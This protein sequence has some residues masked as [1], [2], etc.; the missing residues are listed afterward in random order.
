MIILFCPNC[1]YK[2]DNPGK[3]CSGCG[4]PLDQLTQT[5]ALASSSA[6]DTSVLFSP[7]APAAEHPENVPPAPQPSAPQQ[8]V[9]GNAVPII[10][11][12]S[13]S[14]GQFPPNNAA[15]FIPGN[16]PVNNAHDVPQPPPASAEKKKLKTSDII[17]ISAAALV[18]VAAVI[19]VVVLLLGKASNPAVP[20]SAEPAYPYSDGSVSYT[21]GYDE[22]ASSDVTTEPAPTTGKTAAELYSGGGNSPSNLL[23]SGLAVEHCGQIYYHSNS[24]IRVMNSD[25]TNDRWFASYDAFYLN[26][27]G[28]RLYF[29]INTPDANKHKCASLPLDGSSTT[30]RYETDGCAYFLS[31][32]KDFMFYRASDKNIH[33]RD[34]RNGN[35]V[36]ITGGVH[37]E[38][39]AIVGDSLFYRSGDDVIREASLA[40]GGV[41]AVATYSGYDGIGIACGKAFGRRLSDKA[42]VDL[43]ANSVVSYENCY[44]LNSY[45]GNIYYSNKS[46]GDNIYKMT[47]TGG[48]NTVVLGQKIT[49]ICIAGDFIFVRNANDEDANGDY[50]YYMSTITGSQFGRLD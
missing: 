38:Q 28:D 36:S 45:E 4:C 18:V 32:Y 26:V 23:N 25:G 10:Y 35:D 21:G 42:L 34:M 44:Y 22:P 15:P 20:S 19:L 1:G 46:R 49:N 40:G 30:A 29:T 41:T 7:I 11:N 12:A 6:G 33:R 39:F 43:K 5:Q 24:G 13:S 47:P 37:V 9:P 17:I 27:Y 31:F 8:P 3:F 14:Y 48:A 16:N 2:D 50:R